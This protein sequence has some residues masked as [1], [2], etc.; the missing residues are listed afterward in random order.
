MSDPKR[1]LLISH[2]MT[3]TGAPNSLLNMARLLRSKKWRIT[4]KTLFSGNFSRE[5]LRYG[6]AVEPINESIS[7]QECKKI[8][9]KYDLVICNTVFCAKIACLLQN[10]IRTIL[11]IREAE[12]LPEIL[13]K[14]HIDEGYVRNAENIVCVSEYA[15]SFIAKTYRPKHLWVLHNFLM[16]SN[17]HRPSE[18]KIRKGKVHFL[19]AATIEKR[20]GIDIA[21][22][23]VKLLSKSISEQLVLD[24]AGRKP[25]WSRSFWEGLIPE[26]DIRFKYHGEVTFGKKRL[27][28]RSNVILVPSLDESCSLTALEGGMYGK[29]LIVTENVGAKYMTEGSGFIVKTGSA[30][31]LARAMEFFITNKET[32]DTAGKI[33]FER[34]K[35]TSSKSVYYKNISKIILEVLGE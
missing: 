5:Y 14:N 7:K 28:K 24:I 32:L 29:P 1:I 35:E 2:E 10:Y 19:I 25:E 21:V 22:K 26:N 8:S 3:Y 33:C 12:N 11:L 30:E 23:A 27:F 34:F 4:V 31:D 17:F 9:E 13:E 6:F 18:N 16:T 15:E 20:K